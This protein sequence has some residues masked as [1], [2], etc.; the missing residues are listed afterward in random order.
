MGRK[1]DRQR[2]EGRE[3]AV[4]ENMR[5]KERARGRREYERERESKG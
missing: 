3:Q 5:E 1:R 4:G 2:K